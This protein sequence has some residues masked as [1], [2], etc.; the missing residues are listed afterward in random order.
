MFE[1]IRNAYTILVANLDR[2]RLLEGCRWE[3]INMAIEYEGVSW[4]R[5]AEDKVHWL[6]TCQ[7]ANEPS[8]FIKGSEFSDR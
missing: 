8:G 5:V 1:E 2:K 6:G 4:I 7:H 3:V